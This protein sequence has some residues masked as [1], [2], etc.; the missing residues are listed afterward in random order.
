MNPD[1][2]DQKMLVS[3]HKA[4][5]LPQTLQKMTQAREPNLRFTVE[6]S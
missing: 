5:Y 6:K 2:R 1:P 3:V 4:G